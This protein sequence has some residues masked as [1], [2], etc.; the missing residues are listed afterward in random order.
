MSGLCDMGG[1]VWEW[2]LDEYA[3]NYHGAPLDG[4]PRCSSADC[5]GGADRV[6]RGGGWYDGAGNLRA[7]FRGNARSPSGQGSNIGFRLARSES[8]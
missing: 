2:V 6:F 4:S 3:S 8:P 5:A 7:A 1:N